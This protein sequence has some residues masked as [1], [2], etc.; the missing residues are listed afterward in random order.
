MHH[1]QIPPTAAVL[2]LL[3]TACGQGPDQETAPGTSGQASASPNLLL[4]TLDTTRV[5]RIGAYGYEAAQT[6]HL[7][8]LARDGARFTRAYAHVPLTLPSHASLMTGTFPPEHGIHDN[9]RTSLGLE[10]TTLAELF[11]V[12][13]YRTG[14]FIAALALDGSFGLDRG[15]DVYDDILGEQAPGAPRII[16]RRGGFVVDDAL[17]WLNSG[18]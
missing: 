5:D 12:H 8:S 14:A 18:D 4:I 7:D 17:E 6:P 13:G 16:Q 15:F 11:R 9:G 10:L 2:L 3:L 1:R